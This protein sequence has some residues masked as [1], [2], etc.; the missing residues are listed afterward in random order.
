MKHFL[1][2]TEKFPFL[3]V[4]KNIDAITFE[5]SINMFQDLNDLILVFFEKIT[6]NKIRTNSTKKVFLHHL[7]N[8]KKT[9]RKTI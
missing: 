3:K 6:D 9:I 7:S 4:I 2:D 1:N 8:K 5:K